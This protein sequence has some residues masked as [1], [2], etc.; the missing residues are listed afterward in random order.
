MNTLFRGGMV[1]QPEPSKSELHCSRFVE[2]TFWLIEVI[3]TV[4][5]F[6][7]SQHHDL[8]NVKKKGK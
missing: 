8:L 1:A 3:E 5:L 2:H 7:L 6:T 4:A